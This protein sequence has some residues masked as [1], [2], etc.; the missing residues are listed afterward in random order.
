MKKR[1][2]TISTWAKLAGVQRTSAYKLLKSGRLK[3]SPLCEMPAI[4]LTEY[5]PIKR[6]WKRP[7]P[8]KRL[9]WEKV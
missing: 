9:A 3:Y 4:D 1:F 7:E 2:V 5:P 8:D 6:R